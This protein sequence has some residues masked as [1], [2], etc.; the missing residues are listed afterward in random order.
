MLCLPR[1]CT[2][3]ISL[4]PSELY[5]VCKW[6]CCP[7]SRERAACGC[8]CWR[9]LCAAMRSLS[10]I[11]PSFLLLD[12][13]WTSWGLCAHKPFNHRRPNNLVYF[14]GSCGSTISQKTSVDE[15]HVS[16]STLTTSERRT[17]VILTSWTISPNRSRPESE[18]PGGRPRGR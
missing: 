4:I 14:A 2:G 6:H 5:T 1:K 13:Q 16:C 12:S 11:T 18:T 9:S 7:S 15:S 3:N 17:P 8:S 10:G